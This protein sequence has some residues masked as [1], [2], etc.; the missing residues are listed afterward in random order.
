MVLV[1]ALVWPLS[2]GTVS[3]YW[4][5]LWSTWDTQCQEHT[6]SVWLTQ[7]NRQ[8]SIRHTFTHTIQ[9]Y[10][11]INAHTHT[12]VV[13]L[14][15]CLCVWTVSWR[16]VS[17][18]GPLPYSLLILTL[19]LSSISVPLFTSLPPSHSLPPPSP[20]HNPLHLSFSLFN[21]TSLTTWDGNWVFMYLN[22]VRWLNP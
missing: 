1:S 22:T 10:R 9:T 8:I 21:Q 11:F 20:S 18:Q 19:S 4:Y 5:G 7:T 15:L 13:H 17:A 2:T 3:L 16:L 6:L 12:P 14:L